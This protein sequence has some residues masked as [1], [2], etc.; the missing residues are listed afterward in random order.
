MPAGGKVTIETSF[1]RIAD[2]EAILFAPDGKPGM[3]ST[4]TVTDT[5]AGMDAAVIEKTFY[6]SPLP[7]K[8]R[9]RA[10]PFRSLRHS[11]KA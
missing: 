7:P 5:G 9:E 11:E 2:D 8:N 6:P 4:L 1:A 3:T 10:G